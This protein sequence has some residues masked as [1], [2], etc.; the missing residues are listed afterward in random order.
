MGFS[1]SSGSIAPFGRNH[2]S[3]A[4]SPRSVRIIRSLPGHVRV[5]RPTG[6]EPDAD[7]VDGE[8]GAVDV[9]TEEVLVRLVGAT[10][11]QLVAVDAKVVGDPQVHGDHERTEEGTH[12]GAEDGAHPGVAGGDPA[13]LQQQVDDSDHHREV[14]HGVQGRGGSFPAAR[15]LRPGG[16][17]VEGGEHEQPDQRH[18][19]QRGDGLQPPG[20]VEDA[21]GRNGHGHQRVGRRSDQEE[22]A[23]AVDLGDDAP[24]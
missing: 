12:G 3:P 1:M 15:H 11:V 16:E 18:R 24:T 6:R 8:T 9:E 23:V 7:R 13:Q 21:V 22:A 17:D 4:Q 2:G 10:R 5:E 19:K 14:Q 20:R